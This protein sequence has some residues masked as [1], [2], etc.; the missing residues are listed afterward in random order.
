MSGPWAHWDEPFEPG[1]P[2]YIDTAEFPRMRD[3]TEEAR[4]WFIDTGMDKEGIT[5]GRP[6]KV[7]VRLCDLHAEYGCQPE[8][9]CRVEREVWAFVGHQK[10]RA[11]AP[12]LETGEHGQ[13]KEETP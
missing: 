13:I 4:G 8:D 5:P 7:T 12:A 1:W 6:T 3:A 10:K 2:L 9:A 11:E